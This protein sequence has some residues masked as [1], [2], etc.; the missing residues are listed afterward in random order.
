MREDCTQLFLRYREAARL[1]W[2]L[3]FWP[4][5][6]LREVG[7]VL[8]FEDAMARLFEGMILLRIGC[9]DRVRRWPGGLG[10]IVDFRVAVSAP[11]AKLRVDRYL[12]NDGTHEWG[13]PNVKVRSESCELRF[14]AFMDWDQLAPRDYRLLEVLIERL[15][16]R[17]DLVGHLALIEI[18]K[19]SIWLA[20]EDLRDRRGKDATQGD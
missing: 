13:S 2:N 11:G 12:P 3:G 20:K 19:C 10:E 1:V 16:E 18:D 8:A 14:M 6:E 5:P 4:D 17:P 9:A 7:C 15:D